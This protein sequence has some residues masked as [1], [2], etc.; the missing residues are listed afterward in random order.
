MSIL[1]EYTVHCDALPLVDVA[2][3]EPEATISVSVGQPNQGGPPPFCVV[4]GAS[5]LDSVEETLD[6]SPFVAEQVRLGA[7]AETRRYRIVPATTMTEQLGDAVDDVQRLRD[8]AGTEAVLEHAE[9][10]PD[11][12]RQRRRFADREAFDAYWSFWRE[13]ASVTIH[14]IVESPGAD[15][16]AGAP[17]TGPA[18][19]SDLSDPQ[20]EALLA[21]FE[22]GYFEVPRRATLGDVAA[23]LDVS[24]PACSERLRRAQRSL[25]ASSIAAPGSPLAKPPAGI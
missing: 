18:P 20:R 5:D 6:A 7:D 13:Q 3:A 2:A 10:T 16:A 9:V 15:D 22:L 24:A 23:A 14:R 19:G 8:L 4:V 1:V 17:S 25:I 11:G 21:A 12:W